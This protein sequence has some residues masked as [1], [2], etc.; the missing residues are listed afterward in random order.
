M[1]IFESHTMLCPETV[2]LDGE[3]RQTALQRFS[4][5]LQDVAMVYLHVILPRDLTHSLPVVTQT[6]KDFGKEET[7]PDPT[8]DEVRN[9]ALK[10][11]VN[12]G[13]RFAEFVA[14]IQKHARRQ[15][16]RVAPASGT[17]LHS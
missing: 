3:Q 8:L 14:G 13:A 17:S 16:A 5:L 2:C 6:W 10:A 15:P 4:S 12:R 1:Q 9:K 7:K 11:Y